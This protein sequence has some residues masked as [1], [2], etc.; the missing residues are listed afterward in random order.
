MD[1]PKIISVDDHVV[2]PAHVWQTYLPEKYRERGPRVERKRWAPFVHHPGAKYTN[3]EDPD[4]EWGDAWFYEDRLIYVHKKFVAI[5]LEA[6]PDGDVSTFDRTKM[7]MTAVTYDG[8]RPGCYERDARIADFELNGVD[9]SLPFPTFPR[10]CGQTFYEG[11]DKD[12]GLAC[13]R[14]YNDWMVEEWCE[15]SHG[16]NLPL[17]LMPLWDVELAAA[18]VR[19]NAER[20]VRAVCFSELPTHLDLPSIHT[21]HWD[22][23]FEVCNDSGVTLCMHIGSSSTDPK[24]SPDAP[25]GVGGTLAFN[26]SM[27]SLAD[28]LFSGKLIEFPELKLAY[29]EGQIGWIPYALERADTVWDQ[30]DSWQHSKERIPE[31]PS[32]YYYGRVFGC[33]T[34]DRVGLFN[35]ETAGVDNICFEVDYP[36]T[37]TTWPNSKEYVEKMITDSGLDDE[38]AYKV[39]RGNA[40]RMLDLDRV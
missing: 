19:R 3:T 39:L 20:G 12:L 13:V 27:A 17:I 35:L 29:S 22:P 25:E 26:N 33:F 9:G 18:E 14:A 34:A 7:T 2:E 10:F 40:I 36:H 21:G 11:D 32:S 31:P 8:M 6:T 16:M 38:A 28:W 23:V 4:G 24:A 1:V 5:P 15:P 37:D 30:H